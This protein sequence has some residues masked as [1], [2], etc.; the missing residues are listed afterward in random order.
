MAADLKRVRS[1]EAAPC[2]K[3]HPGD[4]VYEFHAVRR[5]FRLLRLALGGGSILAK[6][7]GADQAFDQTVDEANAVLELAEDI[8]AQMDEFTGQRAR[9][10]VCG[11]T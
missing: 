8:E 7:E 5:R 6:A 4:W 2:E 1:A 11:R 10:P 3:H 9:C